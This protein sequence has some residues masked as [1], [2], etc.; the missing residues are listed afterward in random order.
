MFNST[1]HTL[2]L[3]HAIITFFYYHEFFETFN[4]KPFT[5]HDL[6]ILLFFES[7]QAFPPILWDIEVVF[8][9]IAFTLRLISWLLQYFAMTDRALNAFTICLVNRKSATIQNRSSNIKKEY[10]AFSFILWTYPVSQREHLSLCNSKAL[11]LSNFEIGKH[12]V[13]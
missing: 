9:F 3:G 2:L 1:K 7:Q 11:Q 8:A 13:S 5:I 6:A 10:I 12:T 4:T